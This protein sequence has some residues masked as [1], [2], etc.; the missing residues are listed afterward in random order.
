MSISVDICSSALPKRSAV[1]DLYRPKLHSFPPLSIHHARPAIEH[2]DVV[3]TWKG[4]SIAHAHEIIFWECATRAA[5]ESHIEETLIAMF[6]SK[7]KDVGSFGRPA[8]RCGRKL[9]LG[10]R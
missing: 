9:M 8:T 6:V 5:L 7:V 10:S 4:L 2:L 3:V 1:F